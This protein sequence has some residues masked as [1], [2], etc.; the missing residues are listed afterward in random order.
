MRIRSWRARVGV[1]VA[2]IAAILGIWAI[3]W[4]GVRSETIPGNRHSEHLDQRSSD[5]KGDPNWTNRSVPVSND[6]IPEQSEEDRSV[7]ADFEV[8][9]IDAATDQPLS[10]IWIVLRLRPESAESPSSTL[11]T[12]LSDFRGIVR[13]QTEFSGPFR[14]EPEDPTLRSSGLSLRSEADRDHDPLILRIRLGSRVRGRILDANGN[15]ILSANAVATW[16]PDGRCE[17]SIGSSGEYE[18]RGIPAQPGGIE[19]VIVGS[20]RR[21]LDQDRVTVLAH[22]D[23]IVEAPPMVLRRLGARISG[24]LM[25]DFGTEVGGQEVLA[26]RNGSVEQR[27][28]AAVDGKFSFCGLDSGTYEIVGSDILL[29]RTEATVAVGRQVDVGIVREAAG[30]MT[31]RGRVVLEGTSICLPG[32]AS[33]NDV[34]CRLGPDGDFILRFGA[35]ASGEL[36]IRCEEKPWRVFTRY[37]TVGEGSVDLGIITIARSGLFV[38][39]VGESAPADNVM[40]TDIVS[41]VA[42]GTEK[43]TYRYSGC[44]GLMRIE[45][46]RGFVGQVEGSILAG[47]LGSGSWSALIDRSL[48]N[49]AR[50]IEVRLA[51]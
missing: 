21:Y 40:K 50:L 9:V 49:Q 27:A 51:K 31:V 26:R 4:P 37:I 41:Y 43:H 24:V 7:G 45:L 23:E 14:V 6:L 33:L 48:E 28:R 29:N 10:G 8:K 35:I 38:K 17:V 20:D 32:S 2:A 36:V 22:P 25:S 11:D 44:D 30:V 46:P 3:Y 15:P 1:V 39:F 34:G 42:F 5:S 18:I 12:K 47:T 19:V 13:F 16:K